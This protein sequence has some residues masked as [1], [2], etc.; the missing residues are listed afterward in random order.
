[1]YLRFL[2]KW[3]DRSELDYMMLSRAE[4]WRTVFFVMAAPLNM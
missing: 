1:M 2:W 3:T 4:T